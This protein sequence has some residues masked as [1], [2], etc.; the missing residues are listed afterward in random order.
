M[1]FLIV[2][3]A[4]PPDRPSELPPDWTELV[5]VNRPV[6]NL[7]AFAWKSAVFAE[8]VQAGPLREEDM[9]INQAGFGVIDGV[10]PG[11]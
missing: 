6:E 5:E 9:G 1:P 10:V 3:S 11:S 4:A 2:G 8:V 7:V